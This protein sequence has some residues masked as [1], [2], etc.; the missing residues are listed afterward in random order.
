MWSDLQSSCMPAHDPRGMKVK[1]LHLKKTE[2][3]LPSVPALVGGIV[4]SSAQGD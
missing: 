1:R 4:M 2:K 3:Q